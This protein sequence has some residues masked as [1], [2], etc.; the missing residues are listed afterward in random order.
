MEPI[1]ATQSSCHPQ[2]DG[3]RLTGEP[4]TPCDYNRI[5]LLVESYGLERCLDSRQI[6]RI[7]MEI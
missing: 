1:D 6:G 3:F 5:I 7:V 4:P 2:S